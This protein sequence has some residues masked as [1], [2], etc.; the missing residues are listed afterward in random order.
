M[1]EGAGE[2][3]IDSRRPLDPAAPVA[4]SNK[5]VGVERK[6]ARTQDALRSEDEAPFCWT[7][8]IFNR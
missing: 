8:G 4:G 1:K 2:H 3:R 5:G 7:G 6:R